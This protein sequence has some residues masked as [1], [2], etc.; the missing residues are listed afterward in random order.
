[1]IDIPARDVLLPEVEVGDLIAIANAGAYCRSMS[2]EDF[3]CRP[4]AAE[5]I[6]TGGNA[7][8]ARPAGADEDALRGQRSLIDVI[9]RS[10]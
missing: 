8:L 9:S 6:V 3:L 2:P 7:H 5:W 1:M 10:H 4:S